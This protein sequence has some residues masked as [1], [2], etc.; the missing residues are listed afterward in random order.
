MPQVYGCNVLLGVK[1]K[2]NQEDRIQYIIPDYKDGDEWVL[3][4]DDTNYEMVDENGQ[5]F[6]MDINDRAFDR[7]C[8]YLSEIKNRLQ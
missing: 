4:Y 7:T 8:N 3:H 1:M 2:K 5:P 6:D